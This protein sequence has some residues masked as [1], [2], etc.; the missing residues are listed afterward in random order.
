MFLGVLGSRFLASIVN[1]SSSSTFSSASSSTE[2]SSYFSVSSFRA[3]NRLPEPVRLWPGGSPCDRLT[4]GCRGGWEIEGSGTG[5]M[6]TVSGAGG[7][8][9]RGGG[10]GGGRVD[11]ALARSGGGI[12]GLRFSAAT[13]A[14]GLITV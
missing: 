1:S 11:E 13:G 2:K 8:E 3:D 6:N 10:M 9:L 4:S 7:G 5:S 14:G 12:E